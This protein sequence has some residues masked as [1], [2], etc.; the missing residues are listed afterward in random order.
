[1]K[2]SKI[3][4]SETSKSLAWYPSSGLDFRD[5]L[6]LGQKDFVFDKNVFANEMLKFELLPEL[7]I[8]TD[9]AY[10]EDNWPLTNGV[11][12]TDEE[13]SYTLISA[14]DV[15]STD[16][17]IVGKHLKVKVQSIFLKEGISKEILFLF[18]DN[19]S[20]FKKYVLEEKLNIDFLINIRDGFSENGG[21][22]Y[23]LKF[24]EFY[25]GF[26]N[27]KYLI[28]DNFGRS[29]MDILKFKED[30]IMMEALNSE[31]NR[32]IVLQGLKEWSWSEFGTFNGDAFLMMVH[33][34]L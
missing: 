16:G 4:N 33:K 13:T 10:N 34:F 12:Y 29:P 7:F 25:L 27:T 15:E 30:I 5:L 6:V 2:L 11:V 18:T 3:I 1:M 20:F 28:S 19:I 21:A 17:D 24:I 22:D 14:D 23:S 32:A 9:K 26:M 31:Q 8:H